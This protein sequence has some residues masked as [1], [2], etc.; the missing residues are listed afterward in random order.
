MIHLVRGHH[1]DDMVP[2]PREVLARTFV[3]MCLGHR[4]RIELRQITVLKAKMS[5]PRLSTMD[6]A[7]WIALRR[8]WPKWVELLIIVK[9]ETVVRWSPGRIKPRVQSS[10]SRM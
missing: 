4:V 10:T 1:I 7:F 8:V 5:R 3:G 2:D 9:P 6:R